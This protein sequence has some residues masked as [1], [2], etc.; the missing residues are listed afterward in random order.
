MSLI[1]PISRERVSPREYLDALLKRKW[2]IAGIVLLTTLLVALHMYRLPSVYEA[3]T[4]IRIDPRNESF[5]RAQDIVINTGSDPAYKQTQLR[6]LENPQLMRQLALTLDLPHTP[7]FLGQTSPQAPVKKTLPTVTGETAEDLTAEQ[8]AELAP[9]VNAL[10]ANLSLEPVIGTNLVN[11]R[12]QHANPALAMKVTDTLARLFI[13]NDTRQETLGAKNAEMQLA[14]QLADLQAGIKKQEDERLAYI[15]SNALPLSEG[16]GQNL[17]A[18]RLATLSSELLAAENERR[19][20]QTAYEAA[21]RS[22][23]PWTIPQIQENKDVQELR[24]QIRGLERRLAVLL[25]KYTSEWPEVIQVQEELK[26]LKHD[27]EESPQEIITAMRLRYETALA[28]EQ[29]LRRTYLKEHGTANQQSVAGMQLSDFNQKLET[30]KQLFNTLFQRQKEL[31]I[32]SSSR[33]D[34][35]SIETPSELPLTPIGPARVRNI[36][37]SFFFSL[38]AGVGLALLLHR[39]DGAV[40]SADEATF[41][42]QLPILAVV[43]ASRKR[44]LLPLRRKEAIDARGDSPQLALIEDGRSPV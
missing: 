4:T 20:F 36:F 28:R 1:E 27:L 22:T 19:N 38:G 8:R 42:T 41:Y 9:Y 12:F 15:Q 24:V 10:L 29:E 37:I 6:L 2:L 18:E 23:N 21:R 35:V 40:V 17:T 13:E 33:S 26:R 32:N 43:P 44:L 34:S 31:E 11:I 30:D 39:F 16:K 5:L 14:R 3:R 25:T 7:E